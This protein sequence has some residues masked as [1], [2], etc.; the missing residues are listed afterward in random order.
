MQL[1]MIHPVNNIESR[2]YFLLF[3]KR[4]RDR[5]KEEETEIDRD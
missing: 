4:D 5:Q 3:N 2:G 1:F